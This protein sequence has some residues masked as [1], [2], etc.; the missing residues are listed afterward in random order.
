MGMLVCA[1]FVFPDLKTQVSGWSAQQVN[2][3]NKNMSPLPIVALPFSH[4]VQ[5]GARARV[6]GCLPVMG[7]FKSVCTLQWSHE[8]P[9]SAD[10]NDLCLIVCLTETP[11]GWL[12]FG[13]AVA[14]PG[15]RVEVYGMD[16]AAPGIQCVW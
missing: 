4:A 6:R 9:L 16:H 11:L 5:L 3:R 15:L 13:Q 14:C 10:S 12:E 7:L 1:R 8:V 2:Q